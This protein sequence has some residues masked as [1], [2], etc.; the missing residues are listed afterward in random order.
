MGREG[1][2]GIIYKQLPN[3]KYG[4]VSIGEIVMRSA[5]P[6]AHHCFLFVQCIVVPVG[7]KAPYQPGPILSYNYFFFKG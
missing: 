2:E 1:G 7:F 3:P 5:L 6:P 4:N